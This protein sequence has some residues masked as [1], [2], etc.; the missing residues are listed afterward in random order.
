MRCYIHRHQ[1][2]E[3]KRQKQTRACYKNT[4]R[5]FLH[6][7]TALANVIRDLRWSGQ[8][9]EGYLIILL[10]LPDSPS[11]PQLELLPVPSREKQS[12]VPLDDQPVIA[13]TDLTVAV[14]DAPWHPLPDHLAPGA[15][16]LQAVA[17][18]L[19]FCI[20]SQESQEGNVDRCHAKLKGFEV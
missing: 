6:A 9:E 4:K 8:H 13:V 2:T 19:C 18:V 12:H 14:S 17:V 1:A 3:A 15:S 10:L 5:R 16:H 11:D 7:A 20:I